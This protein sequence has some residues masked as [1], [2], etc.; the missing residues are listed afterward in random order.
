M[1]RKHF[2]LLT[3]LGL[4]VGSAFF[5]ACEKVPAVKL[6]VDETMLVGKWSAQDN[7]QEFWRFDSDHAGETWDQS[8]DVQE[9]EGIHYNWSV[10]GDQLQIDNYGEMGQHVYKDYTV[11]YQTRD[12]LVWK[13]LY[14]NS[15]SFTR[16]EI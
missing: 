15:R 14:G 2:L 16:S 11:T 13:D 3:M 1:K 7:P 6:T 9:G 12:S 4:I 5:S 10:T 8:E